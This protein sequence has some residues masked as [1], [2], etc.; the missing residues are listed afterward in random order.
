MT[1]PTGAIDDLDPNDV[2]AL[3]KTNLTSESLPKVNGNLKASSSWP[4]RPASPKWP[5]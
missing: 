3:S 5:C 1:K 4:S 2:Q